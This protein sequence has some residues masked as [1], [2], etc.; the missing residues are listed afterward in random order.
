[1]AL[2][3]LFSQT[4]DQLLSYVVFCDWLFFALTA[5]GIFALR[6]TAAARGDGA[7]FFSTPGHPWTT[8][9]FVAISAGVVANSFIAAPR[10][11]LAGCAVLAAGAAAYLVYG[12][13]KKRR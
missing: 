13:Q 2:V 5:A 8:S 3:L 4:Y 1:M 11:A 9:I 6:R 12:R 10:Q 7:D